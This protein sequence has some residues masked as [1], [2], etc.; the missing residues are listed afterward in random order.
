MVTISMGKS[1]SNG[2]MMTGGIPYFMIFGH[3][4]DSWED[5]IAAE[6]FLFNS[7]IFDREL[8]GDRCQIKR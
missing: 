6:V 1:P 7:P 4:H 8:S 3:L 2:W 5:P